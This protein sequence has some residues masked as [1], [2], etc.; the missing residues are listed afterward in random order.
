MC[1]TRPAQTEDSFPTSEPGSGVYKRKDSPLIRAALDNGVDFDNILA[2]AASSHDLPSR[3]KGER[4]ATY[5]KRL[6]A[7]VEGRK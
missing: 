3:L 4:V 2:Y 1:S 7:H 5:I 6:R